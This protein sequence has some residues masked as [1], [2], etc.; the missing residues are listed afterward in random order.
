M[1]S[2]EQDMLAILKNNY[3]PNYHI[4]TLTNELLEDLGTEKFIKKSHKNVKEL[5]KYAQ[6]TSQ[7]NTYASVLFYAEETE[8][9]IVALKFNTQLY[10]TESS[11]F[12]NLG[13]KLAKLERSEEALEAYKKALLL[14]PDN[15]KIQ[16]AIDLLKANIK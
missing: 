7:L 4:V 14:N 12:L 5:Q 8:K 3:T 1:V 10:P 13:N 9:A 11:T 2:L 16:E 6:K 15:K